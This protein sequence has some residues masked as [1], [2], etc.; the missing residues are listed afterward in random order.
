MYVFRPDFHTGN[1]ESGQLDQQALDLRATHAEQPARV[2]VQVAPDNADLPAVLVGGDILRAVVDRLAVRRLDGTDETFHVLPGDGHRVVDG[3]AVHVTELEGLIPARERIQN[4]LAGV[5]EDK[6]SHHRLLDTRIPVVPLPDDVMHGSEEL[7]PFL[8]QQF[9]TGHL[10]VV[11][12]EVTQD[13]P[14]AVVRCPVPGCRSC[15]MVGSGVIH[16][17]E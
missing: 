8:L 17:K 3:P 5:C 13:I 12:G 9:V 2:A 11:P 10:R 4:R 15:R 7:D 16:G 6:A 1:Q 14:Q